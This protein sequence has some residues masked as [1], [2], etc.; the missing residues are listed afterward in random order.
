MS[1]K[2]PPYTAAKGRNDTTLTWP[3]M[4]EGGRFTPAYKAYSE[5]MSIA[6]NL[7]DI[8]SYLTGKKLTLRAGGQKE[9]IT[10]AATDGKNIF[11]PKM[12]PNRL[13]ATKHELAHILFKSNLVLRLAFVRGMIKEFEK[14]RGRPLPPHSV[15]RLTSDLCFLINI[16]DDWR[17]NSCWGLS[18]PGDGRDMDE[19]YTEQVAPGMFKKAME[20]FNGDI[21]DLFPYAILICLDQPAVSTKW[22]RFEGDI[23]RARDSVLW[24]SFA[25][26]LVA[27]RVLIYRILDTLVEDQ[28]EPDPLQGLDADMDAARAALGESDDG[29]D[30][31]GI[32]AN[33]DIERGLQEHKEQQAFDKALHSL[34]EGSPT[35]NFVSDNGGF[36]ADQQVSERG[37]ESSR[38]QA[39]AER[40]LRLDPRDDEDVEDFLAACGNSLADEVKEIQKKLAKKAGDANRLTE[41]DALAKKVKANL[42]IVKVSRDR[43][44]TASLVQGDL[45][46]AERWRKQILRVMGSLKNKMD[47]QGGRLSVPDLIRSQQMGIP[48]PCFRQETTGRGFEVCV[49]VDMSSSMVRIFPEVERLAVVLRKALDFPF[50]KM[51]VQGWT[52]T[53]KGQVTLYDY[54][55]CHGVEG[56]TSPESMAQGITPLSFAV[57]LA[58][59][60][61]LHSRNERHVFLLS[62]GFPV[63]Q[64]A[65]GAGAG[66][67]TLMEW[68]RE[69]VEELRQK[70]IHVWC[71]MIGTHVPGDDAMDRMFG[72]KHWRKI[73]SDQIYK[74]GFDFLSLQF[75]NYLRSR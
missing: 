71:W 61:M 23:L 1:K 75:L 52:S 27:C 20:K 73:R 43:L 18:Y 42:K 21:D 53:Y 58:G 67:D 59:E 57:Q 13:V 41:E 54:P 10:R 65:S 26:C 12:H 40:L 55:T 60:S 33:D 28:K 70:R 25:A 31:P 32:S 56:L 19:Y 68:T 5:E 39:Q 30:G 14:K 4:H 64:M 48:L 34:K 50:V 3:K 11:L 6:Y 72:P 69:A 44:R 22:G 24:T 36:D 46:T 7:V 2:K 17:V 16:F 29:D 51:K 74:D 9:G 49:S 66:T 45:E 38:T 37:V 63:Y 8:G 35:P 62:D 47:Y 15:E